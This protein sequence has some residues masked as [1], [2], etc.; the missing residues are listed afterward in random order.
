MAA[1]SAIRAGAVRVTKKVADSHGIVREK[2]VL[3]PAFAELRT[4][5]ATLKAAES[6]ARRLRAEERLLEELVEKGTGHWAQFAP[7]EAKNV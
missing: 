6:H 7:P 4:L 1:M 5:E 3:N 2:S